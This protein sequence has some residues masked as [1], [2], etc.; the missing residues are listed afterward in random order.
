[1][2]VVSM[3]IPLQETQMMAAYVW[4]Q[5]QASFV[6]RAW[7]HRQELPTMPLLFAPA[8]TDV[9]LGIGEDSV[10]Q[11]EEARKG[12]KNTAIV[13]ATQLFGVEVLVYGDDDEVNMGNAAE[14]KAFKG[15]FEKND[16]V[17]ASKNGL[18]KFYYKNLAL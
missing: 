1:T 13:E 9:G 3:G 11:R 18:R 5:L 17:P 14:V 7:V 2:A 15:Y 16:C 12:V 4:S 6:L 10:S 8:K